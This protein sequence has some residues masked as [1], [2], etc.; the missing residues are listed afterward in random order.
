MTAII[1]DDEPES[2]KILEVL[3][4]KVLPDITIL[5]ASTS[6]LEAI[7]KINTLRPEVLFLDV[8]MP[9]LNGFELLEQA[10]K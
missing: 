10:D 2:I 5:A 8:H 3:I 6:P 7:E 4:G 9:G 1:V